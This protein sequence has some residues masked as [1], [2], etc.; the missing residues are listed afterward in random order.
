MKKLAL[1]IE[2]L[3]VDAFSTVYDETDPRRGTVRARSYPTYVSE[4]CGSCRNSYCALT[5]AYGFTCEG[6]CVD[7]TCNFGDGC[8]SDGATNC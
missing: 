8:F 7:F 6:T 3:K 2:E 1:N 5:C 4:E